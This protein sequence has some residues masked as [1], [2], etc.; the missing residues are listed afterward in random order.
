MYDPQEEYPVLEHKNIDD[1]YKSPSP[2]PSPRDSFER[3]KKHRHHHH[4]HRRFNSA[5]PDLSPVPQVCQ[6]VALFFLLSINRDPP[7]LPLIHQKEK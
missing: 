3:R 5:I 1:T 6:T 4:K 7:N 2:S